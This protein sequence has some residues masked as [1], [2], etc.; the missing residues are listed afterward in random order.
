MESNWW[1]TRIVW[2]YLPRSCFTSVH[3]SW[4]ALQ[5]YWLKII[6]IIIVNE[7]LSLSTYLW[8]GSAVSPL[9]CSQSCHHRFCTSSLVT[10]AVHRKSSESRAVESLCDQLDSACHTDAIRLLVS[11]ASDWCFTEMPL[12]YAALPSRAVLLGLAPPCLRGD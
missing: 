2:T 3:I 12:Y 10:T 8:V 5:P 7:D 11:L 6:I 9:W 4:R 1:K